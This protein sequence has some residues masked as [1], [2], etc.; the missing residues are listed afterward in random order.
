MSVKLNTGAPTAFPLSVDDNA[1]S[2]RAPLASD[3][4]AASAPA[5]EPSPAPSDGYEGLATS[6]AKVSK[7]GPAIQEPGTA[8]I[9]RGLVG[10]PSGRAERAATALWHLD[11]LDGLRTQADALLA[12]GKLDAKTHA[13]L[14]ALVDSETFDQVD[15]KDQP[16]LLDA[17]S[18]LCAKDPAIVELLADD[19]HRDAVDQLLS[20]PALAALPSADQQRLLSGLARCADGLDS[21]LDD[22]ATVLDV[23][24]T[25][26][27]E[28]A[29]AVL[30]K[31]LEA[32]ERHRPY[33]LGPL[34][35]VLGNL[36]EEEETQA[37][38]LAGLRESA[39]PEQYAQAASRLVT[40][41]AFLDSIPKTLHPQLL[42]LCAANTNLSDTFASAGFAALRPEL[43]SALCTYLAK[44]AAEVTPGALASLIDFSNRN[45][46]MAPHLFGQA[47]GHDT[48]PSQLSALG[49]M[50]TFGAPAPS[51]DSMQV[52][53]AAVDAGNYTVDSRTSALDTIVHSPGF[54]ALPAS[55]QAEVLASIR[56]PRS[57]TTL[58]GPELSRLAT[59]NKLDDG[60]LM[61]LASVVLM[62]D[63]PA[64]AKQGLKGLLTCKRLETMRDFDFFP[65]LNADAAAVLQQA[66]NYPTSRSVVS[67]GRLA[68]I[69]Q[70]A[71]ANF[72]TD[73]R[74]QLARC[75]A[76]MSTYGADT[77]ASAAVCGPTLEKLLSGEVTPMLQPDNPATHG[78]VS[79]DLPGVMYLNKTLMPT[80]THAFASLDEGRMWMNT[81]VHET[82]HLVNGVH[83]DDPYQ[84]FQDEY[85]AFSTGFVAQYG[86]PPNTYEGLQLA[87]GVLST[88]YPRVEAAL[89]TAGK[90]LPEA[91][92]KMIRF[93]NRFLAPA[94]QLDPKSPASATALTTLTAAMTTAGSPPPPDP[95][96]QTNNSRPVRH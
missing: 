72:R 46:A 67:L 63:D 10:A 36:Y 78:W 57:R 16:R 95:P 40:S 18:A 15:I 1:V 6:D 91:G 45:P 4:A 19:T 3:S 32:A 65:G 8:G 27:P 26:R 94:Y 87:L 81:M 9:S 13:A 52:L 92:Q 54:A 86:R 90:E 56:D 29:A 24:T 60:N 75:V 80:G 42:T 7:P 11:D 55:R 82:N 71:N 93:V 79:K 74:S 37:A 25:L 43:K 2:V 50:L 77:P 39:R 23:S 44:H 68:S 66:V 30:P 38:F 31:M 47:L 88:A 59:T 62:T 89:D 17:L 96:R 73:D 35:T 21:L 61:L 58:L 64:K 83:V 14:L 41:G 20:L 33:E 12:A 76:F 84:E 22:C 28:D 53:Y 48:P 70:F 34:S 85:S 69:P 49:S 5:G 51:A